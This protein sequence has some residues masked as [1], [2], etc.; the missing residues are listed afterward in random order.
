[1]LVKLN[2]QNNPAAI[3]KTKSTSTKHARGVNSHFKGDFPATAMLCRNAKVAMQGCNFHPLW[4]LHNGACGQV[5]EM[6]FGAGE[7][8]NKG[9]LPKYIVCNFPLYR[10]PVWD[11]ENPTVSLQYETWF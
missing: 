10:G 1:M 9:N 3:L 7:S 6:I 11:L 2:N 5:D 8:P 4:G